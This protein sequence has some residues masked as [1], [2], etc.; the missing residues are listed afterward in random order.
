M[1]EKLARSLASSL[2]LSSPP[3]GEENPYTLKSRAEILAVLGD[4]MASGAFLTLQFGEASDRL[5]TRLLAV[6][7]GGLVL[8][9]GPDEALNRR[10]LASRGQTFHT[11]QHRIQVHFDTSGLKR[12][13]FQGRPAFQAPLPGSLVRLQRRDNFRLVI[14]SRQQVKCVFPALAGGAFRGTEAAVL[15]IS[16]GGV[17]II[18][19]PRGLVLALGSTHRNCRIT[20]PE[21]GDIRTT[22]QVRNVS[23]LQGK[24]SQQGKR[25][26]CQFMDLDKMSVTVIQRYILE[27]E[28]EA[29]ARETGL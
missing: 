21:T 1:F 15:N 19:P 28:R 9:Y 5:L 6:N 26:G 23:E 2:G 3:N 29:R 16:N 18:A 27:N 25:I 12:V 24:G 13:S 10:A 4:V 17:A 11:Q 8:D 22:V 14:P 7:D 20:L